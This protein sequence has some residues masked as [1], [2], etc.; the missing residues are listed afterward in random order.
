M[1]QSK[2]YLSAVGALALLLL[3]SVYAYTAVK[4]NIAPSVDL[5]N[6]TYSHP[7]LSMLSF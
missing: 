4:A 1:H 2:R 5:L 7:H 6:H 3:V